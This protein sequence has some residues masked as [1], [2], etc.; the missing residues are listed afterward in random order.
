LSAA[1]STSRRRSSTAP[2]LVQKGGQTCGKN[3][4]RSCHQTHGDR[5]PFWS[6]CI[7]HHR[8]G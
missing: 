1:S 8:F 4:S 2:T 6:S 3:S 7:C 5:R